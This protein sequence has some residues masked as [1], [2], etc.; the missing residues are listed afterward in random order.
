MNMNRKNQSKGVCVYV[1]SLLVVEA[2]KWQNAHS[3][4]TYSLKVTFGVEAFIMRIPSSSEPSS[5]EDKMALFQ[6]H[7]SNVQPAR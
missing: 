3:A 6:L 2:G 4:S 1:C 7:V 5:E